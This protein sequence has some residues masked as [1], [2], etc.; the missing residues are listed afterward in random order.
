MV[1]R[2]SFVTVLIALFGVALSALAQNTVERAGSSIASASGDRCDYTQGIVCKI[3]RK[4]IN[5]TASF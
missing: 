4:P 1:Q 2:L 3:E 5:M